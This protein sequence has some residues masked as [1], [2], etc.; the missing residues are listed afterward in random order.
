VRI[1]DT[2]PRTGPGGPGDLVWMWPVA[3]TKL[4]VI[5]AWL[6]LRRKRV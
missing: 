6:L 2:A 3:A 4:A 5:G 1:H